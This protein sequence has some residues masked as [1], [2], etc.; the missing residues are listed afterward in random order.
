MP[1]VYT[2]LPGTLRSGLL[3]E[4][5]VLVRSGLVAGALAAIVK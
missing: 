4:P 1:G 5:L 2:V 3:L